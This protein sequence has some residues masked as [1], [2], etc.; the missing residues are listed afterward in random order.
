MDLI[1]INPIQDTPDL[2]YSGGGCRELPPLLG[3]NR[4]LVLKTLHATTFPGRK[5]YGVQ[6]NWLNSIAVAISLA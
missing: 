4:F 2:P 1:A 5:F 6:V 3:K